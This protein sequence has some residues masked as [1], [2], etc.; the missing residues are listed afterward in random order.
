VPVVL[1]TASETAAQPAQ[2]E[3]ATAQ[4]RAA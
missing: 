3:A 2:K 4:T 1:V